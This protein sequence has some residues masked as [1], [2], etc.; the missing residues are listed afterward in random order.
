[1]VDYK[2]LVDNI[3]PDL[4]KVIQ[5]LREDVRTI[6]V[7][8]ADPSLVENIPVDFSG[9]KTPLK[10]LAA[11]SCPEPRQILIQPWDKSY[12]EPIE[13]AIH[14]AQ[15]SLSLTVEENA[16]RITLPSMTE[17]YREKIL[18]VLSRKQEEARESLRKWRDDV[19]KGIQ[20]MFRAK[21]IS[22]DEKFK[23]KDELQDLIDE[24]DRKVD[25]VI[26]VKVRNLGGEKD[27]K[28]SK[29][30]KSF[31]SKKRDRGRGYLRR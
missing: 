13:Q 2:E 16:I 1:M 19:M 30:K 11:I 15:E 28:F 26:M 27:F 18:K 31:K 17:E 24:Y 7:G 20:D 8:R 9:I 29:K 22:E 4:D 5:Y 23:A 6:Q 3:K 12:F 14:R 25:S 21:K 10:Q